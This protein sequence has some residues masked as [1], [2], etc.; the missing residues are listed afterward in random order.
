M[1][2][3]IWKEEK[4]IKLIDKKCLKVLIDY[5]YTKESFLK[6]ITITSRGKKSHGKKYYAKDSIAFIAWKILGYSPDDADF[7]NWLSR[8]K[9]NKEKRNWWKRNL[10][11]QSM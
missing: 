10:S 7:Q 4:D 3:S 6:G 9:N 2:N 8:Q 1:G 11:F 5:G